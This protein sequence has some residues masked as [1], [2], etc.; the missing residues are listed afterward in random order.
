M[1]NLMI[2]IE[3]L[4][5]QQNAAIATIA[6][7]FFDPTTGEVG[8]KFYARLDWEE[9]IKKGGHFSPNTIKWWLRQSSEARA[10]IVTDNNEHTC[11]ALTDFYDF[12]IKHKPENFPL[13]VW[14]KSPS[15]DLAIIREAFVRYSISTAVVWKYW[16][17]RDVRTVEAI[18]KMLGILPRT[19]AK[20]THHAMNDVHDQILAVSSVM[21][22]LDSEFNLPPFGYEEETK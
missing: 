8:A 14:A 10:E 2:D 1:N 12:I 20:P 4:S 7:A 19:K 21:A 6:A 3:T 13:Y 17:E 15:F 16:D 11:V 5:Q 18:G 9:D 22:R